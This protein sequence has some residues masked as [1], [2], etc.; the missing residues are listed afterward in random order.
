M[1][2][3][4]LRSKAD[5]VLQSGNGETQR[6]IIRKHNESNVRDMFLIG[7]LAGAPVIKM[8]MAQGVEV[9][10]HIASLRNAK[11]NS[12]L[13]KVVQ[14]LCPKCFRNSAEDAGV[15][16][17]CG[18]ALP[19]RDVPEVYDVLIAGAGAAGLNAA[20]QCRERG[21]S[22]VV[23]E[24]GR[25]ANTIENFPE[26][27]WIYAEPDD[28]PAKGKLWLDGATKEDLIARW[29][30]IVRDN[31]LAVH[32]EEALAGVRKDDGLFHVTTRD[33]DTGMERAYKARRV[34]IAIGQRGSPRRLKA[35]GEDQERVYHRL[36][37]PR[38]Y[39]DEDIL[40]VGGGNSAIEAALVLSE[41][42]RVTLSYRAN[43]F[44]RVFKDNQRKVD[45][46]IKEG[47]IKVLW[48]STVERFGDGETVFNVAEPGTSGE[49]EQ[50]TQRFDHAFV[51]IGAELPAKFLNSIGIRL[52]NEWRGRPLL[53]AILAAA[54]FVV[55]WIMVAL[56]MRNWGPSPR[57]VL[58]ACLLGLPALALAWRGRVHHDRYAWLG[59]SFIISMSIYSIGKSMDPFK[60]VFGVA[61]DGTIGFHFLGLFRSGGF[62]YTVAYCLVMTVFGAA[63]MKR[64]GF[65]RKDKFQIARYTCLIGCQWLFFFIVP[66]F[67]YRYIIR[68]TPTDGSTYLSDKEAME[69]PT[70][71]D[72]ILTKATA[73]EGGL[74]AIVRGL[75]PEKNDADVWKEAENIEAAFSERGMLAFEKVPSRT[76]LVTLVAGRGWDA[77]RAL[78]AS[79]LVEE[80]GRAYGLLY[81]WPLSSG[82]FFGNPHLF[83]AVWG[84]FLSF[85]LLPIIVLFHGKRYCSWVCGCGGLAETLG[86][87][88]RHLAPKGRAAIKQERVGTIL[89]VVA[90]GVLLL[91]L[92]IDTWRVIRLPT[93]SA[94]KVRAWHS[95]LVDVWGAGILPVTLYPF[96]GGKVWCR[97]WCPLAKMMEI[98]SRFYTR[99]G[100]SRFSIESNSKCIACGE[101]TR[102]CQVGIPVMQYALKQETL[103]NATSSCIGC[104]ICVTVCPM[105]TLSFGKA[106]ATAAGVSLTVNGHQA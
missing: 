45:V 98:L 1:N 27:K 99:M 68:A 56:G 96:L 100:W 91:V 25:I 84:V 3:T 54:P 83:W 72:A 103:D 60:A 67:T 55:L 5:A 101:C 94:D 69:N 38:Q 86:D 31:D 21:L 51:L 22:C 17:G 35:P 61:A 19:I 95:L 36:Y 53:D 10:D 26:G 39:A 29:R 16:D 80:R 97:F 75:Y 13:R 77:H 104:G 42:N 8:A 92:G 33:G 52:E 78:Q 12:P 6:P 81:A 9:I 44:S 89:L 47:R 73:F 48:N 65:D 106:P 74:P 7:D 58:G 11:T 105:D 63:A 14:R 46:A 24:K 102:Y 85:V 64:W 32:T 82:T 41:R 30:E 59:L 2:F 79:K 20:L 57:L 18:S 66:E 28:R 50:V 40:V 23:I 43:R 87:R 15:C 90:T 70:M 88:W 71:R 49:A 93:W 4:W 62:F 34:V 76:V 37:S